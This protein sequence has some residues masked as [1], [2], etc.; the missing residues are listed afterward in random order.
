MFKRYNFSREVA[1]IDA[2]RGIAALLVFLSHADSNNLISFEPLLSWKGY[3]GEIGVYLFFILSGYLI[4]TSAHRQLPKEGGLFAYLIHRCT[5]IMP[6]YYIALVFGILV[7]PALS[8]FPADI[9]PYTIFRNATFTQSFLPSESRAINPV[10]WTLTHEMLFYLLVPVLFLAKRAFP[11]I[12]AL[13]AFGMWCGYNFPGGTVAPF[14][15]L[16]FLFAI[17]MTLAQYELCPTPL[18]AWLAT[19]MAM[20]LGVF[21][22]ST[23]WVCLAW[24]IALLSIALS[25]RDFRASLPIRGLAVVGVSSYSLYIWH[26]ML[27]EIIG[28]KL[29]DYGIRSQHPTL[30]GVGFT[31]FCIGVSWLSYRFIELPGQTMLRDA[32]IR[33]FKTREATA[34]AG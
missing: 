17:G 5:R 24:T 15:Q 21:G 34:R 20:L 18:M 32:I 7:F 16:C 29:S 3:L 33:R 27:I 25:L 30:T 31:A 1:I 2:L 13:A 12:V 22:A 11:L 19:L 9:S 14:L 4:W 6:L 23:G 28:P 8:T 10:I 26:Y